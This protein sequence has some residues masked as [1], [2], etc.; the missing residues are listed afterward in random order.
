MAR[1][2]PVDIEENFVRVRVGVVVGDPYGVVSEVERT[3]HEAAH[4]EARSGKCLVHGGRLVHPADDRLEVV[5]PERV[6]I[7]ASV[8][9]DH[10]ERM[11]LVEV[12]PHPPRCFTRTGTSVPSQVCGP[13]GARRSRSEYGAPSFS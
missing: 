8:P 12:A 2:V 11:I 9:C 3:R 5:D 4:D 6:R 13:S 1:E 10:V 7:D